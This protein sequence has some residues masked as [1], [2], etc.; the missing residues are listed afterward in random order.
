MNPSSVR[1]SS[2]YSTTDSDRLARI[3]LSL[4]AIAL[5]LGLAYALLLRLHLL[6]SLHPILAPSVFGQSLS[7]HALFSFFFFAL[8]VVPCGVVPPV[9]PHLV[10]QPSLAFPRL[11][12]WS[13]RL[14]FFALASMTLAVLSGS[15]SASWPELLPEATAHPWTVIW[16]AIAL[17]LLGLCLVCTALQSLSTISTS[18][19][20]SPTAAAVWG[21]LCG[22]VAQLVVGVLLAALAILIFFEA[23]PSAAVFD[24]AGALVYSRFFHFLE[25]AAIVAVLLPSVGIGMQIVAHRGA[26]RV[27]GGWSTALAMASI[28]ALGLSGGGLELMNAGQSVGWSVVQSALGLLILVP[29]TTL[30]TN[31]LATLHRGALR[32]DAA[33]LFALSLITTAVVGGLAAIFLTDLS[34]AGPLLSTAF[35][36]AVLHYLLGGVSLFAVLAVV[37]AHA[38]DLLGRPLEEGRARVAAA[39]C[40]AGLHLAF[41]PGL[42]VGNRGLWFGEAE[43]APS[44]LRWENLASGGAAVLLVGIAAFVFLSLRA[45]LDALRSPEGGD[46]PPL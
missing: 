8:V 37:S 43:L 6:A 28:T 25:R 16:V 39:L 23:A 35:R 45:R 3:Q 24:A 36:S 17:H 13:M 41:L 12:Q 9:L 18:G 26:R 4:A 31:L 20:P 46:S 11:Q 32:V 10:Q 21:I 44:T 29:A 19:F 34:V 40:F 27:A 14:H 22:A 42:W 33:L 2:W 5:S 1:S 38:D 15:L 30:V 7:A